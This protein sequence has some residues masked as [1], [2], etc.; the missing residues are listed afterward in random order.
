MLRPRHEQFARRIVV[1]D[2][3]QAASY[4]ALYPRARKASSWAAASR[5]LRNGNVARRVQELREIAARRHERTIDGIADEL[6][7]SHELALK[8]G[9]CSAAVAATMGKAKL[10]GLLVN[11]S[12]HR[13]TSGFE[14]C[15]TLADVVDVL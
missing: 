1:A 14:R 10:F 12:E 4:R 13:T 9:Q 6:D 8:L 7:Q 3:S 2:E 15:I 5:L 11:K